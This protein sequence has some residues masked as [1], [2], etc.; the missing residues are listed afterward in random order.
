MAENFNKIK[1]SSFCYLTQHILTVRY[2]YSHMPKHL[3][4]E[5]SAVSILYSR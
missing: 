1:Q 2:L 4:S 3:R 5:N